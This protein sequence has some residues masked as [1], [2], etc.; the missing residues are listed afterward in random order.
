MNIQ[1]TRNTHYY[2]YFLLSLV[3]NYKFKKK[4]LG[5]TFGSNNNDMNIEQNHNDCSE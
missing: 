3:F 5:V 2:V 1:Y 4:S